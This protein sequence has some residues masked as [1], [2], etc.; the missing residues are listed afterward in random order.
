[1]ELLY[2]KKNK[3]RNSTMEIAFWILK[4]TLREFLTKFDLHLFFVFDVFNVCYIIYYDL[5]LKQMFK[6]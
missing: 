1:L 4:K 5:Q 6:G 3:Q 2:N